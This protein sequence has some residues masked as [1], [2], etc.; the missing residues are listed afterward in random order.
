MNT[1]DFAKKKRKGEKISCITCYDYTFAKILNN[2]SIDCILV[3]DSLAMVMLGE[4]STINVKTNQIALFAK[5]V[6]R[7]ATKKYIIADMPFLSYR[8]NLKNTMD[9]VETLMQTG[10]NA[11][12]L[13]GAFGNEKQISHIVESGVPVMGHIGLTPQSVHSLGGYKVQGRGENTLLTQAKILQ[14]CG[15]FA[16]VIE[17]VPRELSGQITQNL[18]IPTIGIGAGNLV[19][20]QV[21]VIADMLGLNLDFKPKFVRDFMRGKDLVKSAVDEFDRQIKSDDFPNQKESFE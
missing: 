16:I 13:E 1:L 3:G 5:A 12:K 19:D 9:N 14:D 20:G 17:C 8:K 15:C 2:T 18:S 6:V 10:V 7:G 11:V 4:K 21:L